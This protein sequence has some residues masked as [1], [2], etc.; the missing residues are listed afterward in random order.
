[1]G[2]RVSLDAAEKRNPIF[3]M[4]GLMSNFLDVLPIAQFSIQTK[5][6]GSCL[7]IHPAARLPI[8]FS[9]VCVC[10]CIY[11]YI[12]LFQQVGRGKGTGRVDKQNG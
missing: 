9:S 5:L 6:S 1:M 3:P 8:R 11:I 4:Q 12:I 10:V 2:L 7:S